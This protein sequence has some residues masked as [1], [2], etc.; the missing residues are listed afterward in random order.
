[1]Y[2]VRHIAGVPFRTEK[3]V[4]IDES[5]LVFAGES[6]DHWPHLID[7]HAVAYRP[8]LLEIASE[9]IDQDYARA[10]RECRV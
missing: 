8:R 1:M 4:E 2:L 10:R 5:R 9:G 3:A 6:L 7:H